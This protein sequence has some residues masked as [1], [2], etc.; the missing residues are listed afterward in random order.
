MPDI[1]IDTGL[2]HVNY[3]HEPGRL[4]DCPACEARCH[5]TGERSDTECIY[6]GPRD[7]RFDRARLE[8]TAEY[9]QRLEFETVFDLHPNGL[10]VFHDGP[11]HAPSVFHDEKHDVEIGGIPG[12]RNDVWEALTGMTG[13]YSYNGAVM[14]SSEFIGSQIARRLQELAVDETQTF[15]VVTVEV[16]DEPEDP[17]GWAI[18]HY[19]GN[20]E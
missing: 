19:V 9:I 14:H 11:P 18:L 1:D 6:S 2:T 3:P 7:H 4:Y 15:T 16:H 17:A 5:C 12:T 20:H 13:Q 8:H 10:V